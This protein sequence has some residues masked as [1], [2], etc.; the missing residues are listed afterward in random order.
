[1]ARLILKRL[2]PKIELRYRRDSKRYTSKHMATIN[3]SVMRPS[4]IRA[5]VCS[6]LKSFAR[7]LRIFSLGFHP[8]MKR[9]FSRRMYSRVTVSRTNFA[10]STLTISGIVSGIMSASSFDSPFFVT[11]FNES[12]R[13][14]YISL[15]GLTD[16]TTCTMLHLS[17][18]QGV[19]Q[20]T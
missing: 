20:W 15:T 13:M 7:I 17:K 5:L 8:E 18:R 10:P 3:Y 4:L 16:V 2:R 14:K 9:R 11:S 1:M 12:S 19:L 6:T